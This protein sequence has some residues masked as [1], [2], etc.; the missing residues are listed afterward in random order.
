MSIRTGV[1]LA[2]G[3]CH[4]RR[5]FL[6]QR[7]SHAG[8][9]LPPEPWCNSSARQ[10]FECGTWSA[11]SAASRPTNSRNSANTSCP[12]IGSAVQQVGVRES[13]GLGRNQCGDREFE[14]AV[15]RNNMKTGAELASRPLCKDVPIAL[16]G[17]MAGSFRSAPKTS[18]SSAGTVDASSR[19]NSA[20]TGEER[21][22]RSLN[23]DP[24]WSPY[25]HKNGQLAH[26]KSALVRQ[27]I[28]VLAKHG[29]E[30][31][32]VEAD[33]RKIEIFSIPVTNDNGYAYPKPSKT[34]C[35]SSSMSARLS[36]VRR[37]NV[38]NRHKKTCHTAW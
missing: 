8:G 18:R 20:C 36:Q 23:S 12:A 3:A 16:P 35:V 33:V 10:E 28:C 7:L 22:R 5:D 13:Q 29:T 30:L 11:T 38:G 1:G 17:T 19:P 32:S 6:R 9:S 2:N 31:R 14:P 27:V 24:L 34:R 25:L 37:S 4:E 21:R 15:I 26:R